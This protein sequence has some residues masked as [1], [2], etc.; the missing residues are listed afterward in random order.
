MKNKGI[1]LVALVITIIILLILVGVAITSLTNTGLFENAKQAKTAMEN[2]ENVENATLSSYEMKINEIVGGTTRENS[3]TTTD[4]IL[5][6]GIADTVDQEYTLNKSVNE[7]KRLIIY[8][9]LSLSSNKNLNSNISSLTIETSDISYP[10]SENFDVSQ[11]ILGGTYNSQY[12]YSFRFYFSANNKF[13]I[14]SKIIQGWNQSETDSRI[15]KII[16]I[17]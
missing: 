16:G 12:I 14:Q 2:A 10:E 13:K 11:F 4:D 9:S 17:K 15:Y 3:Q 7:Y 8:S 5:W 6:D 1:T